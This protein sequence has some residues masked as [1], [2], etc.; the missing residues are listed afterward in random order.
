VLHGHELELRA[1]G[2]A[3]RE[4]VDALLAVLQAA[5]ERS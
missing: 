3:A 4:A 2:P 5:N 1:S